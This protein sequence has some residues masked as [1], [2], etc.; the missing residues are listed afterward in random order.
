MASTTKILRLG[1]LV[2]SAAASLAAESLASGAVIAVPTDTIYGLACLVQHSAAVERL[3]TI[4]VRIACYENSESQL[5]SIFFQGRNAKKPIAICVAE[6]EDIYKWANVTVTRQVIEEL[7]PGQVTLVFTRSEQLN[8]KL[9][10]DTELVGVRI[11]DQSFLREVCR[12]CGGPLALTSANLSNGQSTL[13]VE[14]FSGLHGSLALVCDGGRLSDS[15]EARLGST[16]VDLS[17]EGSYNIIRGG[18][19]RENVETVMKKNG[20]CQR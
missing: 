8:N 5:I 9:N 7:L 1:S 19:V 14:E 11:P 17:Q 3:Y 10:P 13:A 2:T 20:I 6:I 16:V 15:E 18:S 12:L 4:K